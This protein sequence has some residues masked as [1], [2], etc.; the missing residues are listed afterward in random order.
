MAEEYEPP[1]ESLA[2]RRIRTNHKDQFSL[3]ARPEERQQ[4]VNPNQNPRDRLHEGFQQT[5]MWSPGV[6]TSCV[7]PVHTH[8]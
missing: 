3:G 8:S 6:G 7:L 1:P 2:Q 4:T 5:L